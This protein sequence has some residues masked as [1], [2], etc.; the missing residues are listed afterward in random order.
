MPEKQSEIN[1]ISDISF[2]MVNI[3]RM[4]VNFNTGLYYYTALKVKSQRAQIFSERAR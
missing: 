1:F 4:F 2:A 3:L